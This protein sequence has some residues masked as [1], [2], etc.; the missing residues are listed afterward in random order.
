MKTIKIKN[1]NN[2]ILLLIALFAFAIAGCTKS[3]LSQSKADSDATDNNAMTQERFRHGNQNDHCLAIHTEDDLLG[4]VVDIHYNNIG[5]P[6]SI[7]FGGTFPIS[8]SYDNSERLLSAAFG[9]QGTRY[10]FFYN[11]NDFLPAHLD[12]YAFG[13]IYT[14]MYFEY[15]HKGEITKINYFIPNTGN[16]YTEVYLYNNQGNVTKVNA[17]LIDL[18]GVVVSSYVA[19]EVT[20]YDHKK[21]FMKGNQWLK[22]IFYNSGFEILDYFR[23]FSKNNPIDYTWGFDGSFNPIHATYTYNSQGFA[24][25]INF[26]LLDTDYVT[27]LLPFTQLSSST[28]DGVVPRLSQ[29]NPSKESLLPQHKFSG[30]L[31][32]TIRN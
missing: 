21:N 7:N 5:D 1:K 15:N 32:R 23:M 19:N 25:I 14:T 3:D 20:V 22:F 16:D 29:L 24:N 2:S 9:S 12:F 30:V 18:N 26:N 17:K 4:N 8:I 11:G 13:G 28:C 27:V 31:P 10:D 6:D